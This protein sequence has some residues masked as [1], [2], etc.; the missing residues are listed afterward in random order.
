M[1]KIYGILG[2]QIR[3][4]RKRLG[5]SQEALARKVKI[6]LNFL[7]QIERGTKRP[8]LATAARISEAL[9][10][11]LAELLKEEFPD[12]VKKYTPQEEAL[13]YYFKNKPLKEKLALV[14]FLKD[15]S[16]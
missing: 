15:S 14:N 11:S 4:Q 16:P 1:E 3:T 8:T 12:S 7:G 6:S 13:L 10:I 5:L 2:K 9:G